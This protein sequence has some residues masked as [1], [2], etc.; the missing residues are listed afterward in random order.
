M[1]GIFFKKRLYYGSSTGGLL[2]V[3]V[4]ALLL[5]YSC[6]VINKIFKMEDW[7]VNEY[8]YNYSE[9]VYENVSF[10]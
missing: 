1:T 7:T 9:T 10:N 5:V 8:Y 2:T 6:F 3:L 4:S